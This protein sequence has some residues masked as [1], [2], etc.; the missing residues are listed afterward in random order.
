[1]IRR[2]LG[3]E[4]SVCEL[5]PEVNHRTVPGYE[6]QNVGLAEHVG[7]RDEILEALYEHVVVGVED[8]LKQN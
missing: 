7:I 5:P 3:G 4:K 8:E 1:V 6:L 2:S